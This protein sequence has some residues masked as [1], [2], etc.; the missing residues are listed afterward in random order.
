MAT[1]IKQGR[2]ETELAATDEKVKSIVSGIIRD[3]QQ[4]GDATIR[5]LSK[6][7]DNWSP[8]VLPVEPGPDP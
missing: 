7:F 8:P 2:T 3:I 4:G 5:E 1:F 6:K